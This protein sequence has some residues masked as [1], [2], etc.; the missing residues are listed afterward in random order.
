MPQSLQHGTQ[1][2]AGSTPEELDAA[3]QALPEVRSEPWENHAEQWLRVF[4]LDKHGNVKETH[5]L[6]NP[7]TRHVTLDLWLHVSGLPAK[8]DRE[9]R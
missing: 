9:R 8:L 3:F 4:W 5:Y 6:R 1:D 2:V 7:R